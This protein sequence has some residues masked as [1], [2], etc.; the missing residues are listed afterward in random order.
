M[1]ISIIIPTYNRSFHI[2]KT[3]DSFINQNYKLG[4]FEIIIID[5]NSNDNT[6]SVIEAYIKENKSNIHITYLSELR[7]GVHYARNT[8]VKSAKFELLYFTDD[9]ML[10]DENLLSEIIKPFLFDKMVATTTGKV[11]PVWEKTP[12][13]WILKHFSN[14]YLSLLDTPD[15]FLITK[16]I[17][18]LYSCHQAIKKEVLIECEGYNPEYVK[19]RYLGDG[20]TGLNNKV[21]N[22]GYKFGFNASSIIYHLIPANRTTQKYINRR[23][24]NGAAAHCYAEFRLTKSISNVI[25]G[26]LINLLFHFPYSIINYSFKAL[27]KRDLGL[28]HFIPAQFSYHIQRLKYNFKIIFYRS[29]RKFVLKS[30]WLSNS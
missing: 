26:T 11:L 17:S 21:K 8:A 14:Q 12:P 25:K 22:R 16:K 19:D 13:N 20:E 4:I 23:F 24:S 9:D 15:E 27:I 29:F 18:F 30:D 7:Q 5:N 28:L 10:A 3:I 1:N 2:S 6:Q